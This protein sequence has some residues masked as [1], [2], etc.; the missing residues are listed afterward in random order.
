MMWVAAS[1]HPNKEGL[2]ADNLRRQGYRV[3]CPLVE[4]ARRHARKTEIVRRPMFPGYVFICLDEAA[5]GCRAIRSTVGVRHL[6]AFGEAPA[7]LPDTFV[8]ALQAR[9]I[10]G[11]IPAPAL[12]HV[13][14]AGST[15]LVKNGIFRDLVATVLACRAQ[16]R[17]V[18]LL[19]MLRRTVKAELPAA[20]LEPA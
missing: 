20:F 17:V 18:V 6:V 3:Y 16:D 15:V 1:T 9:E 4:K 10:D 13:L 5:Q 12:E 11:A 7:R 8:A 2:A 14:P 19:D